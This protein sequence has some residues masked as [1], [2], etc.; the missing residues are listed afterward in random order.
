MMIVPKWRVFRPDTKVLLF[1]EQ[2]VE[3]KTPRM[4]ADDLS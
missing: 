1:I 2:S 3:E 4:C